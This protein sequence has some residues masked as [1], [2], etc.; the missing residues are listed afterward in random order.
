MLVRQDHVKRDRSILAPRTASVRPSLRLDARAR[1]SLVVAGALLALGTALLPQLPPRLALG[2]IGAWMLARGL[3][4]ASAPA[5]FAAAGF[6]GSAA[7]AG[8]SPRGD[9]DSYA[10]LAEIG[11]AIALVAL[12]SVWRRGAGAAPGPRW[13]GALGI[14]LALGGLAAAAHAAGIEGESARWSVSLIASPV[15]MFAC[16]GFFSAAGELRGRGLVQALALCASFLALRLPER[17]GMLAAPA[18]LGLAL[19]AA[20][21]LAAAPREA[22]AL[23][24]A[25]SVLLAAL[26]L[27]GNPQ[28]PLANAGEPL[29]AQDQWVQW[30]KTDE[31]AYTVEVDARV[32]VASVVL[33]FVSEADGRRLERPMQRSATKFTHAPVRRAHL[34]DPAWSVQLELFGRDGAQIGVRVID[35]LVLPQA[36]A[37]SPG[38]AAFL[39]AALL[40]CCVRGGGA[41]LALVAALL[42]AAQSAWLYARA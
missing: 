35:R 14:L 27:A 10:S 32:P 11:A 6:A 1:W 25:A 38:L 29:D 4:L 36:P 33:A 21:G 34:R 31:L 19:V 28:E 20:D 18:A 30:Q 15:L 37:F 22:R 23:G 26:A 8:R 16:A 42:A 17:C 24:A 3:G 5:L 9:L 7:L 12:V 2:G 13:A 39:A 41:R 40:S